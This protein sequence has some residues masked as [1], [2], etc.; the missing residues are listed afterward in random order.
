MA[1]AYHPIAGLTI[2][3]DRCERLPNQFLGKT[4]SQDVEFPS[5]C[6]LSRPELPLQISTYPNASQCWI[7]T[8][9]HWRD[10]TRDRYV[11]GTDTTTVLRRR[12]DTNIVIILNNIYFVPKLAVEIHRYIKIMS[13]F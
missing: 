6:W 3:G 12:T 8:G 5:R 11:R 1:L 13:S 7:D 2:F 4:C 9:P 10:R